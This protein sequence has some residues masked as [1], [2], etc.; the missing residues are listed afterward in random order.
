MNLS[1]CDESLQHVR[2]VQT[3]VRTQISLAPCVVL[4]QAKL[5]SWLPLLDVHASVQVIKQDLS[6]SCDVLSPSAHEA[7]P[8]K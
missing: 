3:S 6:L 1:A 2:D 5:Q 8:A 7:A 4:S